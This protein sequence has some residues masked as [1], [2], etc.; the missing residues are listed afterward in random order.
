MR[1]QLKQAVEENQPFGRFNG[2]CLFVCPFDVKLV[3][4]FV[5]RKDASFGKRMLLFQQTLGKQHLYFNGLPT[6]NPLQHF[7]FP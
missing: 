3:F 4:N 6:K 1:R 5:A 7:G 2:G